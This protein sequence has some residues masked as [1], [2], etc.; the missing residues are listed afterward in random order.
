[1]LDAMPA[2]PSGAK[3]GESI[4]PPGCCSEKKGQEERC[5]SR[6][7][8]AAHEALLLGCYKHDSSVCVK[9]PEVAVFGRG[10]Q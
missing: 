2:V 5:T 4:A 10:N 9:E 3:R 7:Q 6:R 8:V 1:M